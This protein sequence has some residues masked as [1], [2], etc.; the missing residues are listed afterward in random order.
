MVNNIRNALIN[1]ES[2][3]PVIGYDLLPVIDNDVSTPYLDYISQLIA[4]EKQLILPEKEFGFTLFNNIAHQLLIK[5]GL[6]PRVTKEQI[7]EY[8]K[9]IHPMV[10]TSYLEK[11]VSISPFRYF[12][13]VTFTTHLADVIKLKRTFPNTSVKQTTFPFQMARSPEDLIKS[14]CA[15]E[16]VVYNLVGLAYLGNNILF[17]YYYT[18]DDYLD[19]ISEF[20]KRHDIELKNYKEIVRSSSLLFLGCQYPDWLIRILINTLKPGSLDQSNN[21]QA[22]IFF[23]YCN[24][25]SNSFFLTRHQFDFQKN[26]QSMP[27]VS[28]IYDVL[29]Q[30]NFTLTTTSNSFVF[31]SY[32]RDNLPLVKKIVCQLALEM[33]I[34][35]DRIKMTPGSSINDEVKEGITNCKIFLPVITNESK[36]KPQNEYVR[37]E[38]IYYHEYFKD[39]PKVIPLIHENVNAGQ[40]G[41][42]VDNEFASPGINIFYISINDE[43]LTNQD[44]LKIKS[45]L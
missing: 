21:I 7:S 20:N 36:N 30:H 1:N 17:R 40:L 18:D 29:S 31:I 33:N 24:D 34:W 5:N 23:D 10:D 28:D 22:R 12:M 44:I 4:K 3:I 6:N 27:L 13:N 25:P 9:R 15:Y 37:Q 32:T 35:F 14:D 16:G 2:I 41:M 42:F 26:L 8:A 19:F 38:W 39:N 43:G 45:K 11:I